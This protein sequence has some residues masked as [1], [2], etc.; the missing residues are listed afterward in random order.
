[1][2]LNS[3]LLSLLVVKAVNLMNV[4]FLNG[5]GRY[6]FFSIATNSAKSFN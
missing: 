3:E 6:N 2:D 5:G 4:V 1:M